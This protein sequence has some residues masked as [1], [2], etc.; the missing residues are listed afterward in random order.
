MSKT[1]KEPHV[2]LT[3]RFFEAMSYA[4]E[5]HKDQVRKST[6]IAYISHPFGVASLV[7][8]AGG[9]EDQAIGALL[10][11][12]AED[13]GGEPR[14]VEIAEK[15]GDRVAKIVRGCSDSLVVDDS[16]KAPW[17]ERKEAHLA[18]LSE[19]DA[20]VLMV[21][22]ADKAHNA[23]AIATDIQEIGD[24]VWN[25]FNASKGEILWYYNEMYIGLAERSVTPKLLHPLRAAIAI[26]CADGF[27]H[28]MLVEGEGGFDD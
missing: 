6:D 15:F 17:R 25:R 13:C 19:A 23:R 3:D 26:M 18:H 16:K 5:A 21:T 12:V 1:T 22:A 11:D 24:E 14:L 28:Y 9:D 7:L 2:I 20:D 8:E 4:S 27:E 10:H